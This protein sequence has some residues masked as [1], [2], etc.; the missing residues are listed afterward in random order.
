MS[1]NVHRLFGPDFYILDERNFMNDEDFDDGFW[2]D[3]KHG[4]KVTT[5]HDDAVYSDR[6]YQWDQAAARKADAKY[7]MRF[8]VMGQKQVSDW[9]SIYFGYPVVCTA[10]AEGCNRSNGYPYNIL[11]FKKVVK[12]QKKISYREMVLKE[13]PNAK[14]EKW[15]TK[16][17]LANRPSGTITDAR[18]CYCLILDEDATLIYGNSASVAWKEAAEI[19]NLI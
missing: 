1:R 2:V 13:K 7:K 18:T 14:C 4:G 12:G 5:P 17:Q 8:S 3:P 16:E 10:L 6:L 9:L 11:W 15:P 19:L